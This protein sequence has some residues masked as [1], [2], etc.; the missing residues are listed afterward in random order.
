ML[1][2]DLNAHLIRMGSGDNVFCKPMQHKVQ[3]GPGEVPI[4]YGYHSD[5]AEMTRLMIVIV[6]V[7]KVDAWMVCSVRFYGDE[8]TLKKGGQYP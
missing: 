7:R 2:I 3:I 8:N 4:Q 5:S 1:E 6:A